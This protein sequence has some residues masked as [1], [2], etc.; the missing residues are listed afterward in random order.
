MKYQ[1]VKFPGPSGGILCVY[2]KNGIYQVG[3][4]KE[5]A[6]PERLS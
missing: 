2:P 1:K 3:P 5:P 4:S 6:M